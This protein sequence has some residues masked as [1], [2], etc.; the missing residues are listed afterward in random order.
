MAESTSYVKDRNTRQANTLKLVT[1]EIE[2][3]REILT[4]ALQ[5]SDQQGET[6]S[7]A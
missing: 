6:A 1:L 5:G 4:M 7:D 2:R 3:I